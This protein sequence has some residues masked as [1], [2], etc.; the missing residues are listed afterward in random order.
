MSII[1]CA[2]YNGAA[3]WQWDI[4][5]KIGMRISFRYSKKR[6]PVVPP[7]YVVCVVYRSGARNPERFVRGACSMGH[8]RGRESCQW[9]AHSVASD[10][11]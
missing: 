7:V 11:C 10:Q 9:R 3:L 8:A 2:V 4:Q 1:A 5:S 6:C